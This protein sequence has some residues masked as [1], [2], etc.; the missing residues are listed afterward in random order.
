VVGGKANLSRLNKLRGEKA[1][2]Q[3][4]KPLDSG[5]KMRLKFINDEIW[6]IDP[7]MPFRA[8]IAQGLAALEKDGLIDTS[9]FEINFAEI[10]KLTSEGNADAAMVLKAVSGKES[11]IQE[12]LGSKYL[13]WKAGIDSRLY[14]EGYVPWQPREGNI[15]FMADS[16]PAKLAKELTEG[17]LKELNITEADIKKVLAVGGKRKEFI[18]KEELA[19]TLDALTKADQSSD[20]VRARKKM[21]KGWKVWQLISPRRFIKYNIRNLTGDADAAF[22]GNAKVFTKVPRAIKELLDVYQ[23]DKPMSKDLKKWFELGGMESTLQFQEMGDINKL[24]MFYR[25]YNKDG[26][27]KDLPVDAWKKYWKVARLS[28]DFRESILRYAAYLDFM[29]KL[30]KGKGKPKSFAASMPEEVMALQTNEQKAFMLS[31]DLLGAYD[32]ISVAGK[33]MREHIFPFWSWKEVNFKRYMRMASNA[34]SEG[35]TAEKVGRKVLGT[36]VK[37]PLIAARIGKFIIKATAFWAALQVWNYTMF[38]EEEESLPEN[39]KNRPHIIYGKDKDGNVDYFGR[40]GALGD[41]LEWF[42]LDSA[43]GHVSDWMSGRKTLKEIAL[44]MAKSPINV[45]AQGSLPFA[46][47][48]AEVVTRRALFPDVFEPRTVRDRWLHIAKSFGMENEFTSLT[49]RPNKPYSKSIKTLFTYS[50]DPL[51]AAYSNTYENK[52]RFM[53]KIG[54]ESEGFWITPKGNAL[55]NVRLSMRYGDKEAF[56][57][58]TTEYV[59]KYGGKPENMVRSF[60]AMNPLYGMTKQEQNLFLITL[61]EAE[62]KQLV[63]AIAFYYQLLTPDFNRLEPKE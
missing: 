4:N 17:A 29:E 41:L 57:H 51:Q 19:A 56:N 7:T 55:Y 23:S 22:V 40:I 50:I 54:K 26:S 6:D 12:T 1:E 28:T 43:P 52:R 10:S 47:I 60:E 3:A 5:D 45:L 25:F 61:N 36:A 14:P 49:K 46:K 33:A 13:K 44:E 27:L 15:F 62:Q 37:S 59:V 31:N 39:V 18:I 2:I 35:N 48:L 38:P 34:A 11:L 8:K 32:R 63:Q 16:I 42:G 53:K 21:I 24:K 30:V 58:Y 20:F 9:D